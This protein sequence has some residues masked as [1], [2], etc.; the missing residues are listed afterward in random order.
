M[1][2]IFFVLVLFVSVAL[3]SC[4]TVEYAVGSGAK[5]GQSVT[6]KNHFVVAG[7]VPLSTTSPTVL[8]DDATDY[9]VKISHSFIDGLV[10][11]ITG[12]IYTPTTTTVTK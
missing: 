11:A 12:G 8:A 6:G 5:T 10:A 9:T 3:T 2:K 1:K 7:L 4:Y